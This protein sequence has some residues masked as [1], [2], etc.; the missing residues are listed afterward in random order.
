MATQMLGTEI[1][2]R[3]SYLPSLDATGFGT[4]PP[5]WK[6]LRVRFDPTDVVSLVAESSIAQE[7]QRF[8]FFISTGPSD[9]C[10]FPGML[11]ATEDR[12]D[13]MSRL[14][15]A[16]QMGNEAGFVQAANETDWSQRSAGDFVRATRLALAAGAH[17]LARNLA[18]WG[19]KLHPEA[20]ELQKMARVLAPPR[21]LRSDLLPEPSAEANRAWL[22]DNADQYK[23]QWVAL[24][25]GVLVARARTAKELRAH[26]DT[27]DGILM[28]RVF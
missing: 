23:G 3:S 12:E 22:R 8:S 16:A 13:G 9:L 1:T 4:H 25:N 27:A 21:V 14:E 7:G 5:V 11:D 26:L 2:R 20:P 6:T 15:I 18:A 24:R 10:I 17:L 28:T 19:A